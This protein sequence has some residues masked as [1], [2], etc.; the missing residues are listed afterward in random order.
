MKRLVF[1]MLECKLFQ[2]DLFL[3]FPFF[4]RISKKV[5]C[6]ISG[7]SSV[8]TSRTIAPCQHATT[9]FYVKANAAS[10]VRMKVTH[11]HNTKPLLKTLISH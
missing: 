4:N 7:P 10:L 1:L 9:Q 3:F 6:S 5:S 11:S 2:N 8:R